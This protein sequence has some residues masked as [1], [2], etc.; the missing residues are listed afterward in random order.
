M[1]D[2]GKCSLCAQS[3]LLIHDVSVLAVL[4]TL[5]QLKKGHNRAKE[6]S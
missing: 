4:P 3:I 2:A 6:H 5:F 1:R